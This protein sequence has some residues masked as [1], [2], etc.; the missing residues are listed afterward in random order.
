[1]IFFLIQ[2]TLPSYQ[3][4]SM[5]IMYQYVSCKLFCTS[6][7]NKNREIKAC[8][9]P[10]DALNESLYMHGWQALFNFLNR[11]RCKLSK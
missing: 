10:I 2:F 11:L 6:L 5:Y 7:G 1:M 8:C 3:Q 9:L 4:S